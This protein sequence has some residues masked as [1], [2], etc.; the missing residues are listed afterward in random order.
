[1]EIKVAQGRLFLC[2]GFG[3]YRNCLF[4]QLSQSVS[5]LNPGHTLLFLTGSNNLK[6]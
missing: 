6:S 5:S 3:V 2:L 4:S 1:M